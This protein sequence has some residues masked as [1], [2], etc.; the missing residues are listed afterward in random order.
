[1]INVECRILIESIK[2]VFRYYS[3]FRWGIGELDPILPGVWIKS[4]RRAPICPEYVLCFIAKES[5]Q[6]LFLARPGFLGKC[7][8]EMGGG[9]VRWWFQ[10]VGG[11]HGKCSGDDIFLKIKGCL[12]PCLLVQAGTWTPTELQHHYPPAHFP[13]KIITCTI[14]KAVHPPPPCLAPPMHQTSTHFIGALSQK[15]DPCQNQNHE[16]LLSYK[17]LCIF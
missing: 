8:G 4:L 16:A 12:L 9:E 6:D 14:S 11:L 13:G 7:L 5:H 15:I 3:N 17:T 10:V 1:M 2:N